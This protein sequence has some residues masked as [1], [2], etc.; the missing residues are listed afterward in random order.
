M[1]VIAQNDV[2]VNAE[3]LIMDNPPICVWFKRDLRIDDH[4]PLYEA[5]Q[6]G[7]LLPLYI[8]EPDLINAPDFG[9][10][11][12]TFIRECLID[13]NDQLS[14]LGQPLIVRRGDALSVL[15]KLRQQTNFKQLYSH[16]ETGNALTFARD[17]RVAIWAKE[18]SILWKETPQNGVIRPL[19][20]RDGWAAQW[21]KECDNLYDLDPTPLN[22][23]RRLLFLIRSIQLQISACLP[24]RDNSM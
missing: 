7:P 14:A 8:I 9:S 22:H 16:E 15:E 11:H 20:N 23:L 12:W 5:A 4:V 1:C 3:G 10:L 24:L 6:A 19:H 13:L 17:R 2:G 18:Q 21:E